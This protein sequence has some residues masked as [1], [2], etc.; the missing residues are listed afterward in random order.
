MLREDLNYRIE[1]TK[2]KNPVII[3]N[4]PIP[5][6][7]P[8]KKNVDELQKIELDDTFDADY[9]KIN[10]GAKFVDGEFTDSKGRLKADAT[11]D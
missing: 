9:V 8:D 2:Y 10:Q 3:I 7:N 4:D 1:N 6:Y 11:P 5:S